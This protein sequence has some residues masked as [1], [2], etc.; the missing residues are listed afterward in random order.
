MTP[1]CRVADNNCVACLS[2]DHCTPPATC[3]VNNGRCGGGGGGMD[4][5]GGGGMDSGGG[6]P[7]E[8]GGGG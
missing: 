1:Y 5:G 7:P 6:N 2:N 3:N 4:S 8:A